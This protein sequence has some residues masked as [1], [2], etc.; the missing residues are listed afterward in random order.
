MKFII[1]LNIGTWELHENLAL[2]LLPTDPLELKLRRIF[3]WSCDSVTTL[4]EKTN[5]F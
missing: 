4:F 2:V 3:F 5:L 1:S